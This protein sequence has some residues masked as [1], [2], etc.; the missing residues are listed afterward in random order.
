MKIQLRY[1][2]PQNVNTDLLVVILDNELK[3]HNLGRSTLAATIDK[4]RR[5]VKAKRLLR[6]HIAPLSPRSAAGHILV[7]S[8]SFDPAHNVWESVKI[9]GARS[10]RTA[11]L[12]RG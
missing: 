2:N 6:S 4:V 9:A 3:L 10:G 8:T 12:R 11:R 7:D 1:E 5:N